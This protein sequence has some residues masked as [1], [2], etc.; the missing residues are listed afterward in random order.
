ML[1]RFIL[2]C[3]VLLSTCQLFSQSKIYSSSDTLCKGESVIMTIDSSL[4]YD[5]VY[6]F[7]NDSLYLISDT[8]FLGI[9]DAELLDAGYYYYILRDSIFIDTSEIQY[10]HIENVK[11]SFTINDSSQCF[12]SH[13]FIFNN[14]SLNA[15]NYNWNYGDGTHAS[16]ITGFHVYTRAHEFTVKLNAE[17]EFGCVDS[18]AKKIIVNRKPNKPI[19]KFQEP[20]EIICYDIASNYY[21]FR[22]DT[23][24]FDNAKTI[25]VSGY[26][27]Y[28][29]VVSNDSCF[30]DT[31]DVVDIVNHIFS[32]EFSN[33]LFF[34]NPVID[35]FQINLGKFYN[36]VD[37]EILNCIGQKVFRKEYTSVVKI[38]ESI[39]LKGGLYY[40]VVKTKDS[41]QFIQH[42]IVIK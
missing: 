37:V 12:L 5:S 7:K 26:G 20:D 18:V 27:I 11:A 2:I 4:P 25:K 39:S 38:E 21:W 8:N 30:S 19:I 1:K 14:E 15:K 22:N 32:T 36:F 24:L 40:L 31:S 28:R 9:F 34:P 10:L 13:L 41:K 17:S 23:L 3:L 35:L 6:W 42:F 33:F 16:T 29:V